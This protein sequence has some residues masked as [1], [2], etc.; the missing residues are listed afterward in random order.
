MGFVLEG[1][2]E[3]RKTTEMEVVV[4]LDDALRG[5]NIDRFDSHRLTNEL[6]RTRTT[7]YLHL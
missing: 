5:T 7:P 1:V 4:P 3:D 6:G 2:G